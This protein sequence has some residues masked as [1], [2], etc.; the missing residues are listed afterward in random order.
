MERRKDTGTSGGLRAPVPF[1]S[2]PAAVEPAEGVPATGTLLP[3]ISNNERASVK[4]RRARPGIDAAL[5]ERRV[6][7]LFLTGY[8]DRLLIPSSFAEVPM[9]SKPID[10]PRLVSAARQVFR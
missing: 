10:E 2:R 8:S 1:C 9:L 5:Q 4:S 7:F 3:T 6:P